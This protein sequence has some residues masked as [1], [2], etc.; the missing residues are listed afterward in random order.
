MDKSFVIDI[1]NTRGNNILCQIRGDCFMMRL[2]AYIPY[3]VLVLL[4][5]IYAS[6]APKRW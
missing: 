2:F 1:I 3:S 5:L 4:S 6:G